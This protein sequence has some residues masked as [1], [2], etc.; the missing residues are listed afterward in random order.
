[1][2]GTNAMVYNNK[3]HKG[4]VFMSDTQLH[5]KD[6]KI[7]IKRIK[8]LPPERQEE[9]FQALLKRVS[10]EIESTCARIDNDRYDMGEKRNESRR[11]LYCVIAIPKDYRKSVYEIWNKDFGKVLQVLSKNP[12]EVNN[13]EKVKTAHVS[14]LPLPEHAKVV[15]WWQNNELIFASSAAEFTLPVE[16]VMGMGTTSQMT[17]DAL[18][19]HN[20][21]FTIEYKKEDEIKAIVV[22]VTYKVLV[23][24]LINYFNEIK[25]TRGIIKQ[26]L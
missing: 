12:D 21:Y 1:M 23:S 17:A 22:R 18:G 19:G 16:R 26:E 8:M 6:V 2:C 24:R 15:V 7:E 5:A 10:G 14:G 13:M 20:T 3:K 11:L 25:G 4:D 9:Q